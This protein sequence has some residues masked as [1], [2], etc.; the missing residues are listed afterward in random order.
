MEESNTKKM[1]DKDAGR[2]E[3]SKT[4]QEKA[5]SRKKKKKSAL[6][7]AITFFLKIGITAI[8]IGLLL[9]FVAGIYINHSNTA[10]PMI[11]DGDLCLTY[12]LAKLIDGDAIVYEHNGEIKFGRI[13]A[14]P[15]DV[16]DITEDKLTVNGYGIYENTVYPTT[17]DG[18]TISFPY[19]VP[20]DTVFVLNDYRDDPN[21]SRCYGGIPLSDTKGKIIML[22]RRRGF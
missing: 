8:V 18:A 20:T 9:T 16:I 19:T 17:A 21:D 10:Y 3:S 2:T 6:Y 5:S 15:G 14:Q 22:L 1:E 7:Y 11:K 13:V 4:A 12:R